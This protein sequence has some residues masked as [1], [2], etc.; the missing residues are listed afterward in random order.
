M[1]KKVFLFTEL[2]FIL[3]IHKLAFFPC[4]DRGPGS[5]SII[6]YFQYVFPLSTNECKARRTYIFTA[7]AGLR[8]RKLDIMNQFR[9]QVQFKQWQ[10]PAM[11]FQR[12]FNLAGFHKAIDRHRFFREG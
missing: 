4:R 8:F 9:M 7:N 2:K 1:Q 3:T 12:V 6:Y 11:N 10:K 5:Y